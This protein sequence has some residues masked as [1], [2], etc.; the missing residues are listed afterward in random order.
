MTA[1]SVLRHSLKQYATLL[2]STPLLLG[3]A[4]LVPKPLARQ[5]FHQWV[6]VM[7][8]SI[9]LTV[10]INDANAPKDN[11]SDYNP[12][13]RPRGTLYVHLNQQTHLASLLYTVGIKE[14][15]TIVTNFEY[16]L[17][18]LIGWLQV[19]FGSVTIVRQYPAQAKA[20]LQAAVQR[21]KEGESVGISIEGRRTTDGKLCPYKKGPAVMAIEAQCDI[22]PFMTHGEYLLWPS[23][24]WSVLPGGKVDVMVLPRI[25]TVGMTYEDRDQL[26]STLREMAE[27]EVQW[28][29]TN[30]REYI[31]GIKA[32]RAG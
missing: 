10:N 11:T 5:L 13:E 15:F 18:P 2:V 12:G 29:E 7:L 28:W 24:S 22:V 32:R 21:L 17:I 20:A 6:N 31:E 3:P 8:K 27:R 25:S 14:D 4:C 30:N 16:S 1:L 26:T 23:G 19:R 9:D